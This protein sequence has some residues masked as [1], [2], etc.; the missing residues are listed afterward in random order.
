MIDILW[1]LAGALAFWYMIAFAGQPPSRDKSLSKTG[2]VAALAFIAFLSVTPVLL[3]MALV[4]SALGDYALSRD[5]DRA[6]LAGMAA[7]LAGH[8]AYIALFLGQGADIAVL[9]ERGL[10]AAALVLA[11]LVMLGWLWPQLGSFRMPVA[12]YVVAIVVMGLAALSLPNSG[13]SA[14]I[15]GGALAFM[16]SD[17]ILAAE[18]FRLA[19]DGPAARAAPTLV[20]I[21]YWA[22]QA[23]IL[24]GFL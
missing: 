24:S 3:A 18:K 23:L 12:A 8:I 14:L 20:W 11:S 2:S 10:P 6:F 5:G 17:A 1:G 21:L 4:L 9:S 7:F 16:A 13:G 19:S 22:A 15:L